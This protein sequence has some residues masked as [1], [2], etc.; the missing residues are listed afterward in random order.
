MCYN[1]CVVDMRKKNSSKKKRKFSLYKSVG[2]LLFAMSIIL[3]VMLKKLDVLPGKFLIFVIIGLFGINFLLDFFLFRKK[4]KKYKKNIAFV[5]AL[6]FSILFIFPM[7]YMGK[8]IN[9]MSTIGA[10]NYKIENYSLVVLKSSNLKNIKDIKGKSIGLYSNTDGISDAKN[11]LLDK[12]E[13]TFENFENLEDLASNLLNNKIEVI[14]AEESILSMM[15]EDIADFEDDIKIIYTFSV[16]IKFNNKKKNV[17]VSNEPFNV[18]ITGIDTYGDISS[19]SRSDVNIIMTVNPKTKQILLTSIPRDY[20][21]ELRGKK[22]SRDKLT[23]A[24]IYGTDMSIGTIEDLLGIEINYYVKINFSSFID[25]INAIGGIEVYSKY[26]FTSIDGYNY[27]EG[28]NVMNG[29]EALSSARERKAFSEGDRQRGADQQAVIEAMIKKLCNKSIL[30]KY[31]SLLNSIEGKFETNM[32]QKQITSLI[33]MQLDDMSSW[34]VVSISVDGSNGKGITYSGGNQ[35]LYVMIPDW[36]TVDEASSTI[37]ALLDGEILNE[38]FKPDTKKSTRVTKSYSANTSTPNKKDSKTNDEERVNNSEVITIK[39]NTI[40][41]EDNKQIEITVNEDNDK[42][43]EI[44][45]E[46]KVIQ[47]DKKDDDK[48][49]DDKIDDDKKDD[50]DEIIDLNNKNDSDEDILDVEIKESDS[51]KDE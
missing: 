12:V 13:V 42:N 43:N 35:E 15:K 3:F 23:H 1:I 32:S 29:E 50:F 17:N 27:S 47:D 16:N 14:F 28:F 33:K 18:Y 2:L 48:I 21:V 34:N 38:S 49:D 11:L 39:S 40:E 9:F 4:V 36:N 8:T 30:S 22:G 46:T 20:Y 5:F 19:V 45:D 24:G 7:F 26:S 51:L 41:D 10:S 25:I 37:R 6:T 31:D 44:K